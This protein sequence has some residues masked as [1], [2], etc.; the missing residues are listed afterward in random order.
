MTT[1]PLHIDLPAW[2]RGR[3]D[4]K[5]AYGTDEERMAVAVDLALSNVRAGTGGPFGAAIF[6]ADS[7]RLVAVGVNS[8]VRLGSS[9]LHAEVVAFMR[10]QARVQG[11]SLAAPGLP[12]HALYSSCDPCAMCLGAALWAG[13]RRIVCGASRQDAVALRFDEGP[14]FPE[15]YDYLRRRGI[16]V[17]HG[18]LRAEARAALEL[19]RAGG[20]VIY[21]A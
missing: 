9:V 3:E 6:E 10:A 13:V 16:E 7:G 18:V 1:R 2:A 11:Y 15:S 5:R 14:V 4:P 12:A 8:V 17:V 20:G 21:N 19:Y